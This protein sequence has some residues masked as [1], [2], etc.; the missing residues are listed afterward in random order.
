MW[1]SVLNVF[2]MD[3]HC[4]HTSTASQVWYYRIVAENSMKYVP[5]DPDGFFGIQI[6]QN[7]ISA[8]DPGRGAYD[9]APDPLV[10]WGEGYLCAHI[11]LSA[12]NK[13][14]VKSL[15][16]ACRSGLTRDSRDGEQVQRKQHFE[17]QAV[18][19]GSRRAAVM[20]L[21]VISVNAVF[22]LCYYSTDRCESGEV[23]FS[24]V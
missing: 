24:G 4:A 6:L 15:A 14:C 13:H 23:I 17:K 10:I 11:V 1:H 20:A 22:F 18:K 2:A 12:G 7:L 8:T 21:N 16:Y 5:P 3:T 9:A 19:D